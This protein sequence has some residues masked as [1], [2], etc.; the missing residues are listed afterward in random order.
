MKA[1]TSDYRFPYFL[2]S[3]MDVGYHALANFLDVSWNVSL[4]CSC[5]SFL[6]Q[7]LS[8]YVWFGFS[9]INGNSK[10]KKSSFSLIS[11]NV[12]L[13]VYIRN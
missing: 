10:K 9:T 3:G 8:M 2:G 4:S 13:W 6:L 11:E 12:L 1:A 5:W 7:S